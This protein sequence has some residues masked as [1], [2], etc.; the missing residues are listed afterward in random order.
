MIANIAMDNTIERHVQ[1]LR[2]SGAPGWDSD[3]AQFKD[4]LARKEYV[5]TLTCTLVTLS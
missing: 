2:E 3:G 5:R 4:W 1:A